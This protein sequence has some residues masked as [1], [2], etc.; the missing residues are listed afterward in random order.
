MQT[1]TEYLP[2]EVVVAVYVLGGYFAFRYLWDRYWIW[3]R[4]KG[5]K[6][7]PRFMGK[8][9]R[10]R[11]KHDPKYF[12]EG[13]QKIFADIIT[14]AFEEAVHKG[15]VSPKK[16]EYMYK[17]LGKRGDMPWL[18]PTKM[19]KQK[20]YRRRFAHAK[21]SWLYRL[22][23]L[24]VLRRLWLFDPATPPD[25]IARMKKMKEE[26]E[27]NGFKILPPRGEPETVA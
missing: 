18:M 17:V 11:F 7:M 5:I 26:L 15:Q 27:K 12:T 16:T 8:L 4:G 19:E 14:D 23:E 9:V 6:I 3:Q 24:I 1:L 20:E 10:R 13:D 22:S 21:P 25:E 2:Y